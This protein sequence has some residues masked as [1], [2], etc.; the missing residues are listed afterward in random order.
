MSRGTLI[1]QLLETL[2]LVPEDERAAVARRMTEGAP[3]AEALVSEA[4]AALA[5]PELAPLFGAGSLSEVA[6]SAEVPGLGPVLGVIDRLLISEDRVIAVD[7]KSNRTVPAREDEVPEGLLRQMGAYRRMLE[8]IYPDRTVEVA[9]YWTAA[10]RYMRLSQ[11]RLAEALA[12][13]GLP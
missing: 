9:L 6:L 11:T 5:H 3:E 10:G 7:Y 8:A 4:L 12:R 1:H 13:A 2:P